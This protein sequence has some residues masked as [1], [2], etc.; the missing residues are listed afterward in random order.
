M[1]FKSNAICI[2]ILLYHKFVVMCFIFLKLLIFVLFLFF[3]T[4]S[5]NGLRVVFFSL[6][7]V[8]L[9]NFF[10]QT[11]WNLRWE[12]N[13]YFHSRSVGLGV[14]IMKG[15]STYTLDNQNVSS[16]FLM[17]HTWGCISLRLAAFLYYTGY[18]YIY[19]YTCMYS[20]YEIFRDLLIYY[21]MF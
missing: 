6:H 20:I 1:I 19:I 9:T 15:Y 14:M 7:K 21:K 4:K 5:K 3:K 18:I 12:H 13:K 8:L 2:N 16:N 10:K 11:Y 17:F